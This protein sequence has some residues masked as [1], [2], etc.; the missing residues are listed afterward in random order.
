[1]KIYNSFTDKFGNE[2]KFDNYMDFAKFWFNLTRKVAINYFP[3]N[4]TKLQHAAA[5]SKEARTPAI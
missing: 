2:Y 5:N 4:F 1:M 3:T